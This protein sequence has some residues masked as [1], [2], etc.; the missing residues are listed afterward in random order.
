[1]VTLSLVVYM[2]LNI[3]TRS[4]SF[5]AA[6]TNPE[7]YSAAAQKISQEKLIGE[8][9][10]LTVRLQE[11]PLPV[12]L[13][14]PVEEPLGDADLRW[15]HRLY[16]L[17]LP[18]QADIS[19]LI[20]AFME[21]RSDFAHLTVHTDDRPQA[22]EVQLGIDGLRT[23]TL[24]FRW[25]D[26]PPRAALIIA[27]LGADIYLVRQLLGLGFPLIYAVKPFEVFSD[28]IGEQLRLA[29][30][31]TLIEIDLTTATPTEERSKQPS[32]P[33]SQQQP[34][35]LDTSLSPTLRA[36]RAILPHAAGLLLF[37]TSR[38]ASETEWLPLLRH[39]S[40]TPPMV[41]FA[42]SDLGVFNLCSVGASKRPQCRSVAENSIAAEVE[43]T[44]PGERLLQGLARAQSKG[45]AIVLL[46]GT[47]QCLTALRD[48]LPRFA[49][50]GVELTT[51]L[52]RG[53][54]GLSQQAQF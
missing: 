29:Q 11:L 37:T 9:A 31:P 52:P 39:G 51:V 38:V 14:T 6:H 47:P 44:S 28:I 35:E 20:Q 12:S 30:A 49:E 50:A 41:L 21:L 34:T 2:D 42:T 19:S 22:L 27:H 43:S 3:L 13:P 54:V 48:E 8:A 15:T 10:R 32:F 17:S 16:D 7:P 18:R 1:M 33:P 26:G 36:A 23:H 24:R 40:P 25:L 53:A 5:P 46:P 4:A 45:E